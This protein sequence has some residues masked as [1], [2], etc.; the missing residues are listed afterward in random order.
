MKIYFAWI[1][2]LALTACSGPPVASGKTLIEVNGE[3]ITEGHLN[4]LSELNPN[5]ARQ[6]ASPAGK[7]QILENLLE[8]ELFYQAAKKEGIHRNAMTQAKIDLYKKV[9]LAQAY[10]ETEA[11]KEAEK[12]YEANPQEFE[13]LKLAHILIR[14]GKPKRSE[15]AALQL[16]NQVYDR[17][18]KGE[19]FEEMAKKFSEDEFSKEQGG[20][21]GD[22]SKNDP[23][24]MRRGFQPL[25][26]KAFTLKVGEIA[27]PIKTTA[28]YHLVTITSPLAKASLEEVKYQLLFQQ[29]REIRDK[30]LSQLKSESKIVYAEEVKPENHPTEGPAGTP[31]HP[32]PSD[33]THPPTQP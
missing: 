14:A 29:R 25:L 1:A 21:I 12:Y 6:M 11:E 27:G 30:L 16:A 31:G 8:Q 2:L 26:E 4:L 23:R 17:L 18:K 7:K 22:V 3:K 24:L 20:L 15:K 5:L 19:K 28:G 10:V 13:R 33:H 9:I 32:Q